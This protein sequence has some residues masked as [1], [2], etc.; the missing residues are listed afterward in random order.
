MSISDKVDLNNVP[1]RPTSVP[2]QTMSHCVALR[3]LHGHSRSWFDWCTPGHDY[4]CTCGAVPFALGGVQWTASACETANVCEAADSCEAVNA[5][6][7]AIWQ[8]SAIVEYQQMM[9]CLKQCAYIQATLRCGFADTR[10][11]L[12]LGDELSRDGGLV[13]GLEVRRKLEWRAGP[14]GFGVD[15]LY[16]YMHVFNDLPQPDRLRTHVGGRIVD[17]GSETPIRVV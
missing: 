10:R 1:Q 2:F 7:Y 9:F 17:Q 4:F 11:R 15:K 3:D 13:I 14:V 8:G 5:F 6:A 16:A 12:G